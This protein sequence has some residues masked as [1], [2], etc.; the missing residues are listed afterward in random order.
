MRECCDKMATSCVYRD[1]KA[2]V[3]VVIA[4]IAG[5]AWAAAPV[6][7][8]KIAPAEISLGEAAAA[9]TGNSFW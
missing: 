2:L 6:F 8:A 1:M 3:A 4:G 7:E 5:A 9:I